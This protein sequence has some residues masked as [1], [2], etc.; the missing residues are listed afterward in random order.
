[1]PS[2]STAVVIANGGVGTEP[3]SFM[4][5]L[6][7]TVAYWDPQEQG[8]G[9]LHPRLL[10][11]CSP[12]PELVLLFSWM[13]ARDEHIAKYIAQYRLLFPNSRI[14]LLRCPLSRVWLP[15]IAR[16]DMIPALSLL[17]ALARNDDKMGEDGIGQP[18]VL[19]H[20]FSNGGISTAVH[21][22]NIFV[23]AQLSKGACD[24]K[25]LPR[26]VLLLDS[27]PGYFRW[28]NTH[29]ALVQTL[30]WW[31][32]PLMHVAIAVACVYHGLRR[33]PAAQNQNARALRAPQLISHECRRTYLYG[34]ADDMVDYRDIEDNAREAEDA[35]FAVRMERFDGAKHVA[36]SRAQPVRYWGAVQESWDGTDKAAGRSATSWHDSRSGRRN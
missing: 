18:R 15:W 21:L 17:R 30:P 28:R 2:D 12:D 10:A 29:R 36:I 23:A 11:R 6:S 20:V 1:M 27:C 24:A 25:L 9:Q 14:L 19:V 26:Y 8:H 33:L 4:R 22:W 34:T 7:P 31:T 35:G 16:R 13:A 32:S 3:L 5:S